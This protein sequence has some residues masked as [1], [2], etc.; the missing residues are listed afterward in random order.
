MTL[1]PIYFS[2]LSPVYPVLSLVRILCLV[3]ISDSFPVTRCTGVQAEDSFLL[4]ANLGMLELNFEYM[5][6]AVLM[7]QIHRLVTEVSTPRA[8]EVDSKLLWEEVS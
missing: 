2:N 8:E 6:Q 7:A 3:S 5:H 4:Q 1:L